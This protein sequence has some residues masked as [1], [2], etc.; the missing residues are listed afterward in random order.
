MPQKEWPKFV[1]IYTKLA[2]YHA[3]RTKMALIPGGIR[4]YINDVSLMV[5]VVKEE[6]RGRSWQPN[7][8]ECAH[9]LCGTAISDSSS[10]ADFTDKL[11]AYSS[12]PNA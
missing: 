9:A 8:K 3:F 7:I 11:S 12:L 2:V 1:N 10:I 5:Y 4:A 6:M